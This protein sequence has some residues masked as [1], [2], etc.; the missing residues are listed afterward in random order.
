MEVNRLT[1]KRSIWNLGASLQLEC[2]ND[3]TME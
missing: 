3:G 2:W 1:S